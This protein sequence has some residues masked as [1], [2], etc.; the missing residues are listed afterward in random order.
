MENTKVEAYIIWAGNQDVSAMEVHNKLAEK[1]LNCMRSL[2]ATW[3]RE[4]REGVPA[5]DGIEDRLAEIPHIASVPMP[6]AQPGALSINEIMMAQMSGKAPQAAFVPTPA[7]DI[8]L[9]SLATTL[10]DSIVARVIDIINEQLLDPDAGLEIRP[11]ILER[12]R[13][14]VA[15]SRHSLCSREEIGLTDCTKY[16]TRQ[17]NPNH[18]CIGGTPGVDCPPVGKGCNLAQYK[19]TFHRMKKTNERKGG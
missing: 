6:K 7:S 8:F 5:P 19:P 4:W 9:Y 1:G 3:I 18:Y 14:S 15:G 17:G 2:I 10:I 16:T 12:L 11:E 13:A